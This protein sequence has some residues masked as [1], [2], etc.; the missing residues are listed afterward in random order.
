[1]L[2]QGYKH[3]PSSGNMWIDSPS[4]FIWR[5]GFKHWGKNVPR[6][7]MGKAAEQAA[8]DAIFGGGTPAEAEKHALG[9]FELYAEDQFP[10]HDQETGEVIPELAASGAIAKRFVE[11]LL[12]LGKPEKREPREAIAVPGLDRRVNYEIDLFYPAHGIVD[13]KATMKMPWGEGKEPTPRVSHVR[14][15][16]LYSKLRNAPA[17]LLYATPKR[18]E[19]YRIPDANGR[20]GAEE[21]MMAFRQIERWDEKFPAPEEAISFIPLQTDTFWWDDEAEVKEANKLWRKYNA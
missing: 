3:S 2:Y 11:L 12:P 7:T 17:S 16:G 14:Q 19:I 5:Y 13:L 1:M 21:L 18:G 10:M 4:A 15:Q 9:L 6:T 20:M 8:Y